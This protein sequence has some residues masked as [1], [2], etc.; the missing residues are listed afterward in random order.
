MSYCLAFKLWF[1]LTTLCC[2]IAQWAVGIAD[3]NP[4]EG[5]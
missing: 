4:E 3:Q 5:I 1:V 2:R